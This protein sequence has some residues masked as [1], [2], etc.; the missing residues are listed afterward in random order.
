MWLYR[1]AKSRHLPFW[2]QDLLGSIC[3]CATK[4]LEDID[5]YGWAF[6]E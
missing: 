1:F 4:H 6:E 2:I 5:S 3:L